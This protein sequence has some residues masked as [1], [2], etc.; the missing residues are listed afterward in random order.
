M[1]YY[2]QHPHPD[3]VASALEAISAQG[4]FELDDVQ[5]PLSGFF[6][7]IFRANPDRIEQWIKPYVGIPGRHILYA[8]LWMADTEASKAAL[9]LLINSS[10][11]PDTA[12]LK[13]LLE[14]A[15]PTIQTMT[16]NGPAALDFL[17]GSFMASGAE[18]P[19]TRVIDQMKF[20]DVKGN[21]EVMMVGGAASWSVSANARQHPKVLQILKR[22]A[23]TA[24]QETKKKIDLILSGINSK[25]SPK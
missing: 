23:E 24:D 15:P 21:T 12:R 3:E 8:A 13:S 2:Y 25:M 22:R 14:T 17:W 11:A 4:Y 1:T 20:A 19:V 10:A 7:E 18:E 5:A 16:I 6:A 9:K